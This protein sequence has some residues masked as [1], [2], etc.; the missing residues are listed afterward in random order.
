MA[1]TFEVKVTPGQR[2]AITD[3][4]DQ[5]RLA[6]IDAGLITDPDTTPEIVYYDGKGVYTFAVPNLEPANEAPDPKAESTK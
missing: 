4:I 6:G 2:I 1:Q 5:A 3:L